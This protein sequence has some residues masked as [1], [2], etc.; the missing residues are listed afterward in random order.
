[1]HGIIKH[2]HIAISVTHVTC[3]YLVK[4]S[5]F[6]STQIPAKRV[7]RGNKGNKGNE[8]NKGNKGNKG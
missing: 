5:W 8:G 4:R 6:I 7:T 2:S 1:M 3:I